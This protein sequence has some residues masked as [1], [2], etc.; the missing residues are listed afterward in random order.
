VHESASQLDMLMATIKEPARSL[1]TVVPRAPAKVVALVDRALKYDPAERW[2]CAE[3]MSAAARAAFQEITGVPIP[4]TT[5]SEAGGKA[6]WARA[7]VSLAPPRAEPAGEEV[8]IHDES[9][10]VSVVFEPDTEVGS[11]PPSSLK[12]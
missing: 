2:Q 4:T 6:G 5:R 7:A 8:V 3:D 9:I 1:A 12:S 10:A 11:T